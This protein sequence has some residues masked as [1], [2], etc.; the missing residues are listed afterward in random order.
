[1]NNI[2][3][4]WYLRDHVG[5][6]MR[7]GTYCKE[8]NYSIIEGESLSLLES[9]KHIASRYHIRYFWVETDSKNMMDAIH[10]LSDG[11]SAFS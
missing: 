6:F 7:A 11:T 1:L 3:A 5:R 9:M 4:G 8:R 2:S 10:N